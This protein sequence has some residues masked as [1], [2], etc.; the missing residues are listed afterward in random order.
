MRYF[1]DSMDVSVNL[2]QIVVSQ[3]KNIYIDNIQ[4]LDTSPQ[5]IGILIEICKCLVD[6]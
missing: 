2:F 6:I 1:I 3:Y 5:G 4:L